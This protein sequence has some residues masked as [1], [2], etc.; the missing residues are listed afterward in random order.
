MIVIVVIVIV[1][2][3]IVIVIVVIVVIVI[4]V[5][6]II[7]FVFVMMFVAGDTGV[8][9]NDEMDDFATRPGETN[10]FGLFQ[11]QRNAPE[12]TKRPLSSMTPTLLLK[13]GEVVAAVGSP[14][15]SRII[16]TVLQV[17]VNRV[18]FGLG[19]AE[20]DQHVGHRV[21]QARLDER[22]VLEVRG[23][24]RDAGREEAVVEGL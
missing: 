19:A 14:G 10:A 12:P 5:L 22:L 20:A 16:T 21:A 18:D 4:V 1:I 3:V 6:I 24:G 9:L 11:S 13:D 23:D 15:G 2:V 7:V 17:I 8:L